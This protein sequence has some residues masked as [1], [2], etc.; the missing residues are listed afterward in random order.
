MDV[1]VSVYSPF[2]HVCV[3][4]MCAVPMPVF[5]SLAYVLVHF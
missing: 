1:D 5:Y 2:M 4:R 3:G